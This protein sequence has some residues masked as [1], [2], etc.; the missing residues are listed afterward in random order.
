M[1]NLV[2]EKNHPFVQIFSGWS[3]KM[4]QKPY[5]NC[6]SFSKTEKQRTPFG[7]N[8]LHTQHFSNL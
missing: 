1:K 7:I 2:K 3:S 5:K 4:K 6:I 8:L